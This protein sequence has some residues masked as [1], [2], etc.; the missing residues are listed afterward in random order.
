MKYWEKREMNKPK[1][2]KKKRSMSLLLTSLLVLVVVLVV[3]ATSLAAVS[4]D[5]GPR[6]ARGNPGCSGTRGARGSPTDSEPR[7]NRQFCGIGWLD[8]HQYRTDHNHRRCRAV[9]R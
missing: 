9:S 5:Q 2:L 3:P 8:N 1:I 6:G 4:G 7:N